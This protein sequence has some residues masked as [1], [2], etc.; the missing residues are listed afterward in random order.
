AKGIPY[1]VVV[2]FHRSLMMTPDS[3]KQL[4]DL[5]EDSERRGGPPPVATAYVVRPDI[6]GATL[7]LP[8]LADIYRK[9]RAFEAFSAQTD[10]DDWVRSLMAEQTTPRPS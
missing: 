5:L 2:K 3:I 4:V 9:T 1:A 6:E 7:M 10:A 8:I